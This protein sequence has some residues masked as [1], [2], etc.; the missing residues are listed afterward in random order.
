MDRQKSQPASEMDAIARTLKNYGLAKPPA[1]LRAKV[2]EHAQRKAAGVPLSEKM[3]R[4]ALTALVAVV[5]WGEWMERRTGE[6]MAQLAANSYSRNDFDFEAG[7]PTALVNRVPMIRHRVTLPIPMGYPSTHI[8]VA[9]TS[10][11]P[12]EKGDIL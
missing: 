12:T 11:V 1:Q 9:L 3:L 8:S 7:A 6:R 10:V 4:M 5:V 2:L